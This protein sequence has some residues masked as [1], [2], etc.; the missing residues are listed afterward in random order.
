MKV[1]VGFPSPE[2][3]GMGRGDG[4]GEAD[5]SVAAVTIY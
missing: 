1:S 2:E 3:G 5:D 4:E